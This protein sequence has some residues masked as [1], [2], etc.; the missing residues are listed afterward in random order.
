[1]R[2][3]FASAFLFLIAGMSLYSSAQNLVQNPGF[4]SVSASPSGE[5]QLNLA[6]PWLPLNASPDLFYRGQASAI[7]CDNV[8]IPGN[9]GEITLQGSASPLADSRYNL[10][11]SERRIGSLLNEWLSE[12]PEE[13]KNAI[14]DGIIVIKR[15]AAGE[16]LSEQQVND[17]AD[18][19][20][21]SVFG[22]AASQ[23]RRI[24]ITGI[25]IKKL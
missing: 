17:R 21:E 5:N 16:S 2:A 8:G 14:R 22:L 11:L 3:A 7:P 20:G 9:A 15:D 24:E 12:G 10:I 1:M 19:V 18:R 13:L 4:E 25:T 23:F 6:S